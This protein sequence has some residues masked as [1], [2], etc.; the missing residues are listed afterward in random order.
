M[1]YVV[2]DIS[3][4]VSLSQEVDLPELPS[5]AMYLQH[6]NECYDW[7]T[8]GW[9]LSNQ[10]ISADDYKYFIFLNSSVRGPILPSYLKVYI[11]SYCAIL[12]AIQAAH[13]P[14]CCP[15]LKCSVRVACLS[16]T[17]VSLQGV[18]HYSE[19]MTGVLDKSDAAG[20]VKLAGP[21][22]NCEATVTLPGDKQRSNP[23]V[24]S[25]A[26]A[27]DQTGVFMGASACFRA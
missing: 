25:F 5:N 13:T 10:T 24:Q 26:V 20:S 3:H 22:I 15:H 27:T 9:A 8:F 4:H 12:Y 7:G 21:T 11:P 23:H 19:L 1:N 18:K 17:A 2:H 6:A 16:I 14:H